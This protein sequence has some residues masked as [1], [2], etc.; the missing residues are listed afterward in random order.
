MDNISDVDCMIVAVAHREF[1]EMDIENLKMFFRET[2]S[3]KGVLLD[4][5]GIYDINKLK[6]SNLSWW[7]L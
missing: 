1:I 6:Q 3:S 5:K 4:V 7:R 2:D